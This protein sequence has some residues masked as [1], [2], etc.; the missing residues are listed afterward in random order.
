MEDIC[1]NLVVVLIVDQFEQI[2]LIEHYEWD[3]NIIINDSNISLRNRSIVLY[4]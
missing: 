1:D 2:M 4:Q 3:K